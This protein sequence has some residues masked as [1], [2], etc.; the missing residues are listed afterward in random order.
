MAVKRKRK[1]NKSKN[2]DNSQIEEPII[3]QEVI[4]DNVHRQ[5]KKFKFNDDGE[6]ENGTIMEDQGEVVEEIT[7]VPI[8]PDVED[9]D[10]GEDISKQE[11]QQ[12]QV[13]M[14]DG[15]EDNDLEITE[16]VIP[17]QRGNK[18][19][20]NKN[21]KTV[22]YN[23]PDDDDDDDDEYENSTFNFKRS[24]AQL[25]DTAKQLLEVRQQLPIYHHREKLW[26]I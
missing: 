15:H 22:V 3:E 25:A 19:N 1:R 12:V 14:N 2:K 9:E 11:E 16:M 5:N 21:R 20:K 24:S 26:N 13:D 17:N 23:D 18:I 8:A 10:I 6:K 7:Q 4:A